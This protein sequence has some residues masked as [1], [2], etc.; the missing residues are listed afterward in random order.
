[1]CSITKTCTYLRTTRGPA[2]QAAYPLA[3][4]IPN[5]HGR[6]PIER[7]TGLCSAADSSFSL[8][9]LTNPCLSKN[10]KQRYNSSLRR[11][12]CSA[13]MKQDGMHSAGRVWRS[14]ELSHTDD[15]IHQGPRIHPTG[16]INIASIP[17]YAPFALPTSSSRRP[18]PLLAASARRHAPAS[19]FPLKASFRS[20]SR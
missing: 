12:T 18:D 14:D 20:G 17:H 19:T 4:W 6:T 8:R 1:M 15:W 7:T 5:A 13:C 3:P 11:R 2:R 9:Y 16:Y 10:L